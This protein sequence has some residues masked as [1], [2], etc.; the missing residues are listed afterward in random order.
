MLTQIMFFKIED[1]LHHIF[2]TITSFPIY[3]FNYIIGS[4]IHSCR[5]TLAQIMH[6]RLLIQKNKLDLSVG[7]VGIHLC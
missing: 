4:C 5:H 3:T 6:T 2:L 1:F 7:R